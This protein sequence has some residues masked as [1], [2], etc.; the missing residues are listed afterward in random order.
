MEHRPLTIFQKKPISVSIE[1]GNIE[2]KKATKHTEVV[3]N[4]RQIG[5]GYLMQLQGSVK[6]MKTDGKNPPMI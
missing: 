2:S 4:I 3:R 1:S 6:T 5:I